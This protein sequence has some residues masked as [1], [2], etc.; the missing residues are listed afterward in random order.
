[1]GPDGDTQVGLDGWT[2]M[3]AME[4]LP[5]EL[6]GKIGPEGETQ[7][8]KLLLGGIHIVGGPQGMPQGDAQIGTQE[9]WSG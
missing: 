9:D 2:H 6:T 3:G 7:D 4:I 8:G 1:M 5:D